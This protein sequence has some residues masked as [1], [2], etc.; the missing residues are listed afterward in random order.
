[1]LKFRGFPQEGID[2]LEALAANNNREWFEAHK[3]TYRST[4]LEPAQAFVASLGARL[5][6]IAPDVRVDTSPNGTGVLMR[7]YRDI[8]FGANKAPYKTNVSGMFWEGSGKKTE[9]PGFGFQFGEGDTGLMSG[10]FRFPPSILERYRQAVVGEKSGV[11]LTEA[12]NSVLAVEGYGISGKH[13]KRI[14]RGY[15]GD[16]PRAE[17]LLYNSLYAYS[18][19]IPVKA[20]LTAELVD[21]CFDHFHHMSPIR[22]WLMGL[23]R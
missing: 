7:I 9:I 15:D 19:D 23:V 17:W 4:V 1:M 2:F 11:M 12:V 22:Q 3:A 6:L 18:P 16:H 5:A 8:R 20:L 10:M 14:P 21:E 13:Y